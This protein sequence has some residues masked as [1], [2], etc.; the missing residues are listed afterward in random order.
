M[1]RGSNAFIYFIPGFCCTWPSGLCS[2]AVLVV[3]AR[4]ARFEPGDRVLVYISAAR[5]GNT[6]KTTNAVKDNVPKK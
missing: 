2:S 4:T 6:K 5:C 1:R 3:C